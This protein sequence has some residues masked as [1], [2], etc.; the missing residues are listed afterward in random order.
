MGVAK[1]EPDEI[2]A[3]IT[4]GTDDGNFNGVHVPDFPVRLEANA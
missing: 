3:R 4:A 2:L 1:Q